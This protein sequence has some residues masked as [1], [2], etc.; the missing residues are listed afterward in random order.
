M[1]L[2]LGGAM[3]KTVLLSVTLATLL[4][5]SEDLGVI[6]VNST[7]IDD[8]FEATSSEVSSVSIIDEKK[9]RENKSSEHS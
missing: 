5:A 8:K 6:S 2:L 9:D 3:K 4:F 7:T 1:S